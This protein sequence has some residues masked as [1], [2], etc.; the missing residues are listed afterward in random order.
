MSNTNYSG[1]NVARTVLAAVLIVM[2][3]VSTA[4]PVLGVFSFSKVFAEQNVT[5]DKLNGGNTYVV[6]DTLRITPLSESVVRLEEKGAKGFE[7]RQTFYI[8]G[9][10]EFVAPIS[11]FEKVGEEIV[12][13]T[14]HYIVHIPATATTL[15]GVYVTDPD[16]YTLY[17]YNGLSLPNTYLPSPYEDLRG[18][19][20][21][22]NPRIVPGEYGYSVT[23]EEMELNGWDFEN[24]A[25]DVYVF[26]PQSYEQFCEDYVTLT[27]KSNLVDLKNLGYWDSRW[28]VYDDETALQQI[29]DYLDKGYSIDVLVIDTNW[30]KGDVNQ[31]PGMDP[32]VGGMG[33][34]IDE[35]LFPDMTAFLE[36]AHEMGV[37]IIFNDHPE[38]VEGNTNGLEHD[39]IEYR[40][41][42]LKL[43]LSY[44]LDMWWYD[45]NWHTSLN[46][47]DEDLS[48]FAWG[49][50]AF[51]FIEDEYYQE[52]SQEELQEYARRAIIMGNIDGCLHGNWKYASDISSHRYTIQWTGDIGVD[53]HALELEIRNAVYGSVE[54]GIPYIS[55]DIGGHNGTVTDDMYSRWMQY[56][57]LST[58]CRV[59]CTHEA[60]INQEG[61]MPW[62]FG[63]TAEEVTKE[64]VG[65]R[66]NLM[67]L[68]YSLAGQNANTG[69]P[70]L[71]RLDVVYPQYVEASRNDQYLLGD[72]ILI[73][74]INEAYEQ[75]TF[76]GAEFTHIEEGVEK[77]GLLGSYYANKDCTGEPVYQQADN[78]FLFDW[79]LASPKGLP[80]DNFSVTW[81]GNFTVGDTD[82]KFA[83]F[84]DDRVQ[85]RIDGKMVV[86]SYDSEK[87]ENQ[88]DVLFQTDY[89]EAGTKHSIEIKYV[90]E[91]NYAH[92]YMYGMEKQGVGES[93]CYND[94]EVFIPDGTWIDVWSG[95]EYYGPYTYTVRHPLETSP[96]FVKKGSLTVL[97][98]DMKN[99]SE[100]D[101]SEL[102]LDAYPSFSMTET[103]LYEDDTVTQAYKY[104]QYRTTKI[105]AGSVDGKYTINI[106]KAVGEFEGE[107]AFTTRTWNIRLHVFEEL[108]DVLSVT[109]NGKRVYGL[110]Y[111]SQDSKS[112]PFAFSG[113]SADSAVYE[114]SLT[115]DIYKETTVVIEF[116]NSSALEVFSKNPNYNSTSAQFEVDVADSMYDY[117]NLDNPDYDDWA[118][119]GNTT[120][121][122]GGVEHLVGDL[123]SDFEMYTNQGSAIQA[124][125]SGA[126]GVTEGEGVF[127]G[128]AGQVDANVTL[129]VKA[130]Q[131]KVFTLYLYTE[132]C[133]GKLTVRDRAGNVQT[134]I[135]DGGQSL[136]GDLNGSLVGKNAHKVMVTVSAEQDTELYVRYSVHSSGKDEGA[137][138]SSPAKIGISAIVCGDQSAKDEQLVLPDLPETEVIIENLPSSVNLTDSTEGNVLDWYKSNYGDSGEVYMKDGDAIRSVTYTEKRMFWDYK[139]MISWRNGE[140][141]ESCLGTA[142]G[143]HTESNGNIEITFN[144]DENTKFIVLYVGAWRGGNKITVHDY[145]G[146][147]KGEA[148]F[149][150]GED[151]VCKKVVIPIEVTEKTRISVVITSVGAYDS[152]NASLSAIQ[153]VGDV[154]ATKQDVL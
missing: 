110:S 127:G 63:D 22:D 72:N 54:N 43:I 151:S 122:K 39:E 40:S 73:A 15:S 51:Q 149:Y 49:M 27:G 64:Y 37:N 104:G 75:T 21:S 62:L 133:I 115:S 136:D 99:L 111:F 47:P 4:I 147:T 74:P 24:K 132:K 100:K 135:L 141:V 20:L 142:N 90:E 129:K 11:N 80:V 50:Y 125:W 45:R 55:S 61:R 26:I 95:K 2:L 131:T 17:R 36:S 41:D 1:R 31:T 101:W 30:R 52:L 18:W 77:K 29:Q 143:Y 69:M 9:R 60:Y 117:I 96:I 16:G 13:Y 102:T 91:G 153:V 86:N 88:Y 103:T 44:G 123:T 146:N 12:I 92:F 6:N 124:D 116:E 42:N 58:I 67:P 65:M 34:E 53:D 79:Q 130:G 85:V 82:M 113:A 107:K 46:S 140:G 70:I 148:V 120:A 14:E 93:Y 121:R 7:D 68:Y 84:A 134:I 150:A 87:Q 3:I 33:Y 78:E 57:A 126:E 144:V 48:V 35:N 94:R 66:Y 138:T 23:D 83:F 56:G 81:K 89:F 19:Y 106:G 32:A 118:Y 28:Y 97:A 76:S 25:P 112:S 137:G 109:V 145:N 38:P 5:V 154:P 59:H 8:L 108:G 98:P 71:R 139:S 128:V 119:F 152:G 10:D 114:F 105:T